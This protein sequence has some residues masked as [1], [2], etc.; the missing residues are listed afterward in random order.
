MPSSCRWDIH[1][2]DSGGFSSNGL[3]QMAPE[4]YLNGSMR[5]LTVITN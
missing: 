2:T 5:H 4:S 1:E 3:V